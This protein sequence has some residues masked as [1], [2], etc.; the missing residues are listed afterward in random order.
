MENAPA[1]DKVTGDALMRSDIAGQQPCSACYFAMS[2]SSFSAR[3]L[4]LL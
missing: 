3:T 4:T 2:F 1:L